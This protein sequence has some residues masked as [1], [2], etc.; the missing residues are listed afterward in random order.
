MTASTNLAAAVHLLT[1]AAPEAEQI[2]L[3]GSQANGSADE[4]SDL[5]FL[6]IETQINNRARERVRPASTTKFRAAHCTSMQHGLA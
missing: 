1:Q 5:D 4:G 6:V 3:F 2:V